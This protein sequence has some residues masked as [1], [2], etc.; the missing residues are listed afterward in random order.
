MSAN[1]Q[2]NAVF[3]TY[4]PEVII[5]INCQ[6]QD[7][8]NYRNGQV[9]ESM[10]HD[11]LTQTLHSKNKKLDLDGSGY[12]VQNTWVFKFKK[13]TIFKKLQQLGF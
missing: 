10:K 8:Y 12:L 7:L 11:C 3:A 1:Q 2:I 5:Y 9:L 4:S 13:K 6:K